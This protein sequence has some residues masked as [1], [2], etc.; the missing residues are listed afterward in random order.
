MILSDVLNRDRAFY[1]DKPLCWGFVRAVSQHYLGEAW[2]KEEAGKRSAK[3]HPQTWCE[4]KSSIHLSS[5]CSN[6]TGSPKQGT[7]IHRFGHS[8][9]GSGANS[10]PLGLE[11]GS[12]SRG[13]HCLGRRNHT[14]PSSGT[15]WRG[16]S[17]A[18]TAHQRA[19]AHPIQC[20]RWV[21]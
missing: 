9:W 18:G 2:T 20:C 11:Q 7:A 17:A 15:E 16:A 5:Y 4:T 1:W 19:A 12:A 21:G 14:P 10:M 6:T 13:T 8:W 3:Y